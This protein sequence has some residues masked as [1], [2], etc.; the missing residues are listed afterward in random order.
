MLYIKYNIEYLCKKNNTTVDKLLFELGYS[1][2]EYNSDSRSK[3]AIQR[4]NEI[5]RKVADYFHVDIYELENRSYDLPEVVWLLETDK[6]KF[7]RNMS[8]AAKDTVNFWELLTSEEALEVMRRGERLVDKTI[9]RYVAFRHLEEE[10]SIVLYSYT[11][12][13]LGIDSRN[14]EMLKKKQKREGPF[15]DILISGYKPQRYKASKDV[16]IKAMFRQALV[17]N[18]LTKL[19]KWHCNSDYFYHIVERIVYNHPGLDLAV[20]WLELYVKQ[21]ESQL[22]SEETEEFR[23]LSQNTKNEKREKKDTKKER[24][25]KILEQLENNDHVTTYDLERVKAWFR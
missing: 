9:Y 13:E 20:K 5:Y 6:K 14:A 24:I 4:K 1:E 22:S 12:Y 17:S 23:Q 10:Y 8:L 11:Y 15:I 7:I 21:M 16:P 19:S 25:R 2:Q 18:Q 3:R